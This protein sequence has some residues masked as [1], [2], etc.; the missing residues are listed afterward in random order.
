MLADL[1][2]PWLSWLDLDDILANENRIM[3]HLTARQ[4]TACP[5]CSRPS[6]AVHSR[7]QR[8]LADLPCAGMAVGLRMQV[9]QWRKHWPPEY[10]ELLA[11]LRRRW[12]EGRGVREFIAVLKLHCQQQI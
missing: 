11:A 1:L 8:Q 2:L 6:E 12:P 9:R 7:Y 3:F 5:L 4:V 10:E